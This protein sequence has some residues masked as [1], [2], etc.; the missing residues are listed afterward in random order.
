MECG[1]ALQTVKNHLCDLYERLGVNSAMEAAVRLGW[2][3]IPGG[4]R[5]AC[6]WVGYCSRGLGHR[7]PHGGMRS[8]LPDGK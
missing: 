8:I 1:I 3:T 4:D 6:G 7:G 5:P 2:V